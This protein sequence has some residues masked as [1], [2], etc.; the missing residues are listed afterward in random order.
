LAGLEDAEVSLGIIKKGEDATSQLRPYRL[1]DPGTD[2][3]P[4]GQVQWQQVTFGNSKT[5]KSLASVF[6]RVDDDISNSIAVGATSR[7]DGGIKMGMILVR[8]D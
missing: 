1:V 2:E 8:T 5:S 7:G 3:P 4:L 6:F